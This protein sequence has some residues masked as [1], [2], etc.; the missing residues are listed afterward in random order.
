M[1]DPE[2]YL[3]YADE[4]ARPFLDLIARIGASDPRVVLDLGCGPGTL[5]VTLTH[6]WPAAHITGV[7]S[8]PHMIARARA[9]QAG[10]TFIQA[11]LRDWSLPADAD[12]VVSNATLQWIP[13]HTELL[14]RWV[15]H[16]RPGS[17][18]AFQVP[19]NFN[20]PSHRA[21]RELAES[22]P[23][24]KALAGVLRKSDAVLEPAEYAELL[25]DCVLDVWETTYLHLLPAGDD[26]PVLTWMEGT[27]LRPVRAVLGDDQ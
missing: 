24:R 9:L 27:A 2:T 8:S 12:V 11:D 16:L 15:S 6:R 19:G 25:D 26:H 13:E 3:R 7:D 1:W 18:L 14:R 20:A 5:T 17:W 22:A 4:R 10:I 23:W 21:L